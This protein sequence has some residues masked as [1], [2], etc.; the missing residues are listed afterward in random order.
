M[1]YSAKEEENCPLAL[2]MIMSGLSLSSVG[3]SSDSRKSMPAERT[4]IHSML[5]KMFST[6]GNCLRACGQDGLTN[7]TLGFCSLID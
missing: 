5:G 3:S 4:W 2:V 6:F 1:T 7:K